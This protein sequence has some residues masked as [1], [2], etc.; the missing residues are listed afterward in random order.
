LG[1]AYYRNRQFTE[2]MN[3]LELAVRGG[4][5]ET[6]AVVQGLPLGPNTA[7]FYYLYGLLLADNNR[8]AEALPIS[9]ALLA[10]VP[11]DVTAV[12]NAQEMI[13]ICE[14][15]ADSQPTATP[16]GDNMDDMDDGG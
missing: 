9:Q 4:T 11:G 10:N 16:A 15:T 1:A 7:A 5:T 14:A 3:T 13:T 6:G 12:A 8:C 2:A